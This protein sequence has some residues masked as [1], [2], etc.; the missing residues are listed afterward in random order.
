MAVF[1]GSHGRRVRIAVTHTSYAFAGI[2]EIPA[3]VHLWTYG[4]TKMQGKSKKVI[5]AYDRDNIGKLQC[6]APGCGYVTPNDLPFDKALIGMPCPKCGASLLT[7]DGFNT[8][9][10]LLKVVDIANTIFGP[11]F[12]KVPSAKN[13]AA[14]EPVKVHYHDG[15]W[16]IK[17][18]K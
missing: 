4:R 12:G 10:K 14:F 15:N 1:L 5:V 11:I 8:M 7:E 17:L 3:F 18:P 6:D 13:K 9:S 16:N 2:D